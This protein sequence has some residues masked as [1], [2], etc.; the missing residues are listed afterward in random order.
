MA[1]NLSQATTDVNRLHELVA[2]F[3]QICLGSASEDATL[4]NQTRPV[5]AKLAASFLLGMDTYA[6]VAEGLAGAG[7]GGFFQVVS[8]VDEEYTILYQDVNGVAIE[9]KRYPSAARAQLVI[10]ARDI[11]LGA[12]SEAESDASAAAQARDQSV[13]ASE[14]SGDV[15]F[16]DTKA[17]ADAASFVEGE[18]AE[19]FSDESR[20]GEVARYRYESGVLVYKWSPAAQVV[21]AQGT[22]S[23]DLPD[24]LTLKELARRSAYQSAALIATGPVMTN[25]S[26]IVNLDELTGDDVDPARRGFILKVLRAGAVVAL[27][28]DAWSYDGANEEITVN[29][30]S[31]DKLLAIQ[32]EQGESGRVTTSTGNQ[33]PS[34]ALDSRVIRAD[35]ISDLLS[36]NSS[37][38]FSGQQ[39]NTL[40]FYPPLYPSVGFLGGGAF[41]WDDQCP[42][43]DHN[44]GTVISPSVPWDGNAATLLDFLTGTGETN[45]TGNGCWVRQSTETVSS[46]S[47]GMVPDNGVDYRANGVLD[48]ILQSASGNAFHLSFGP[49]V[50]STA[51]DNYYSNI[52]I[53]F[54]PG[55]WFT[56]TIHAAVNPDPGQPEVGRPSNVILRGV[57]GSYDRVGSYNCDN[58]AIEKIIVKSDPDSVSKTSRGVHFYLGTNN[59]DVG[60]IDVLDV[61]DNAEYGLGIDGTD[62]TPAKNIRIGRARVFDSNV[63][64]AY[65]FG[66]GI[67]I[68]RLVV[69][70]YGAGSQD[71]ALPGATLPESQALKG[72]WVNKCSDNTFID[73]V[74][75]RQK[76]GTRAN[77]ADG[78]YCD[79]GNYSFGSVDV[80][81]ASGHGFT[82]NAQIEAPR[83]SVAGTLRAV[84]SVLDDL[85][86]SAGTLRAQFV[87]TASSLGNGIYVAA[88]ATLVSDSVSSTDPAQV[89]LL[90]SGNTYARYISLGASSGGD[91]HSA[92]ISSGKL[93][94]DVLR[95]SCANPGDK[96]GVYFSTTLGGKVGRIELVNVGRSLADYAAL[97][98]QDSAG[99]RI[100][101]GEMSNGIGQGL[102]VVSCSDCSFAGLNISG[103]D[104]N[105]AGATLT[106]VGFLNCYNHSAVTTLTNINSASAEF[107]NASTMHT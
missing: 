22:E 83:V 50:Y 47:F 56:G 43:S 37:N 57:V 54:E 32:R 59:L 107:F 41:A 104:Q 86:V 12:A 70:G 68:G 105:V 67:S 14:A 80:G 1:S 3:N 102:R 96:G 26:N 69:E 65:I 16:F 51:L 15:R 88:G 4:D 48:H 45:P 76:S 25:G 34:E 52:E 61:A 82:L 5:L 62:A 92:R 11:T 35:S 64:G 19:V 20:G 9:K 53:T 23:R 106:R 94:C 79:D 6:T 74:L 77:A 73:E 31:G 18:I 87:E 72:V 55:S 97:R 81:S 7:E 40:S 95:A 89:G 46:A 17:N 66:Y 100:E 29:A 21:T 58:V 13:A 39:V 60:E 85:N 44:G 101:S 10:E 36:I 78:V 84:S 27:A 33:S 38:L 49:G 93:V 103:Y 42:K 90:N 24:T 28:D 75:V 99:I 98:V 8:D 63:H 71:T 30:Q 91:E 2:F